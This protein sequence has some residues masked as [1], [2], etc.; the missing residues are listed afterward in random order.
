[1]SLP[2][3]EPDE[4]EKKRDVQFIMECQRCR[5][6]NIVAGG[7]FERLN[8]WISVKTDEELQLYERNGSHHIASLWFK[9]ASGENY[10]RQDDV[11][12]RL[13]DKNHCPLDL[14]AEPMKDGTWHL[15]ECMLGSAPAAKE[16]RQNHMAVYQC[17]K[18]LHRMLCTP[19]S[20]G[21]RK[22]TPRSKEMTARGLYN[23]V[24]AA[25]TI[26]TIVGKNSAVPEVLRRLQQATA[27]A[28]KAGTAPPSLVHMEAP[29]LPVQ[30]TQLCQAQNC[31]QRLNLVAG[32]CSEMLN[33][34]FS[35]GRA[36]GPRGRRRGRE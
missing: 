32:E 2:I 13:E 24:D 31:R 17:W 15:R 33:V 8:H 25:I 20:P 28:P 10:K 6:A 21:S 30:G 19:H 12:D 36:D 4:P 35:L 16:L 34:W 11:S 14:K 22:S 29:P 26:I 3:V 7:C 5:A 1:M 27:F 18:C 9:P 23:L